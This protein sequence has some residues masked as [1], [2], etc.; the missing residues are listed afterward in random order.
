LLAGGAR[1]SAQTPGAAACP[2]K[3]PLGQLTNPRNK[4][5]NL[6]PPAPGNDLGQNSQ[7]FSLPAYGI[8]DYGNFHVRLK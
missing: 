2:D 4:N 7:R 8:D 6:L 3:G 1:G 5:L